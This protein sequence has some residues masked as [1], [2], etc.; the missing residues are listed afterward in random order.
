[1]NRIETAIADAAR[2]LAVAYHAYH[3]ERAK[4]GGA[5][6]AD[7]RQSVLN[8]IVVW[9][10]ALIQADDILKTGLASDLIRETVARYTKELRQ[11]EARAAA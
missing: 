9:G 8:G 6:T 1:M 5:M 4:L 3:D 2:S 11:L 7:E 10:R